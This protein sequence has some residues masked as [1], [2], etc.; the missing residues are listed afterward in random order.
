MPTSGGDIIRGLLSLVAMPQV[1]RLLITNPI[2]TGV[3]AKNEPVR[4]QGPDSAKIQHRESSDW[5]QDADVDLPWEVEGQFRA[6][7]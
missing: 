1:Q 4:R 3:N 2:H 7:V 5:R 6:V